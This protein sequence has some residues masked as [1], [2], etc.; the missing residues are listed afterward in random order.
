MKVIVLLTLS[1]LNILMNAQTD[2]KNFD[3]RSFHYLEG[4]WII[5]DSDKNIHEEWKKENE[6][7]LTSV[8][9]Y[10][11]NGDTTNTETISLEKIG[12]DI[13]YIPIVEHNQGHVRFKLTSL[14]ENKAV[15]ENPG[16]DFPTKIVYE[17]INNDSLNASIEGMI[18]GK[19]KVIDYPFRRVK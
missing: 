15:F 11:K 7:L 16:H 18:K 14:I 19:L 2:I 17:K 13:F 5:E 12:D 4:K 1:L 10:V 3:M 9:F 8:S 6:T